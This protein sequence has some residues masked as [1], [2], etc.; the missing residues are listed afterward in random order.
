[1][2]EE[3]RKALIVFIKS[4]FRGYSNVVLLADDIVHEAYLNLLKS[5]RYSPDKENFGYLSVACLR[6]AYRQFMAQSKKQNE[7]IHDIPNT[8]LV[9]EDDF[10]NEVIATENTEIVLNSLNT[11]KEI[12]KIVI[13][14]R[15][16]GDFSFAE[17]AETN[18]LKL[19]TVLSHHRR[20]LE[21]LRPTL[22]R[23]LGLGKENYFE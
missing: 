1:M 17:I 16:Y 18:N 2:D 10:V 23:L 7:L 4:K 12:E 22:T 9:S 15:Y 8:V 21:K 11:L 19:N 6:M 5:N 3:L 13:T 20:A 14:Q